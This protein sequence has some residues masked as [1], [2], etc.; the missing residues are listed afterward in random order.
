MSVLIVLTSHI[1]IRV[2]DTTS[3]SGVALKGSRWLT[4][5]A[6][7]TS[8]CTRLDYKA[9]SRRRKRAAVATGTMVPVVLMVVS[10]SSG[11]IIPNH[12][13]SELVENHHG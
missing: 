9:P 13:E 7:E 6:R 8:L 4:C 11:P 10:P 12:T 3:L 1:D 5:C 2:Y